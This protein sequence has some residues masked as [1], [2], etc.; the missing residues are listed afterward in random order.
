MI[1]TLPIWAVCLLGFITMLFLVV[2][3]LLVAVII[4]LFHAAAEERAYWDEVAGKKTE[5]DVKN[6]R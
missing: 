5:K 6:V 4:S 1:I 3:G 2:V